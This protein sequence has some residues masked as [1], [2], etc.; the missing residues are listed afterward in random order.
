MSEAG[1]AYDLEICDGSGA[2]VRTF[3]RIARHAQLYSAAQQ[4]ADFP[5]GLPNPLTVNVYQLSAVTGRGYQKKEAL[6]VR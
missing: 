2:V 4:A 3:A 5:A 1:E 6:Y